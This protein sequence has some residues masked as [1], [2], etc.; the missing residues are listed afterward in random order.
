VN[1]AS[2]IGLTVIVAIAVALDT[3]VVPPLV[4]VTPGSA[5]V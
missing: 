5:A 2:L 1:G 3:G 4:L